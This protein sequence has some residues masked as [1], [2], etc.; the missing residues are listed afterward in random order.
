MLTPGSCL[1]PLVC[2]LVHYAM[3]TITVSQV[4]T[5]YS[6]LRKS[7]AITTSILGPTAPSVAFD[8][9][10]LNYDP[11]K[12]CTW[13]TSSDHSSQLG[14][15]SRISTPALCSLLLCWFAWLVRKVLEET[16]YRCSRPVAGLPRNNPLFLSEVTPRT[17][18]QS[19]DPKSTLN[20]IQTL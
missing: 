6:R 12:L 20:W 11:V 1:V 3:L 7:F 2:H 13:L 17:L 15:S 10:S 19:S 16:I 14:R 9:D 4:R 8:L 5:Y 18:K